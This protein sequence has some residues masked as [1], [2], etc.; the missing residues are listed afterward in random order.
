LS[1]TTR[2]G[3][4]LASSSPFTSGARTISLHNLLEVGDAAALVTQGDHEHFFRLVVETELSPRPR[5]TEFVEIVV[6]L[7][8]LC[9]DS[10]TRESVSGL[11]TS[12]DLTRQYTQSSVVFPSGSVRS[13][14]AIRVG[15]EVS[16][17]P[18]WRTPTGW[19]H[20]KQPHKAEIAE[21]YCPATQTCQR[22]RL[23]LPTGYPIMRGHLP[24]AL[25]AT[26]ITDYFSAARASRSWAP[27]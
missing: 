12:R 6:M 13:R 17:R 19:K 10:N 16:E 26:A 22:Q 21:L 24:Y 15:R 7:G 9:N 1:S 14:K 2:T 20:Q 11:E 5:H 3:R 4:F 18:N 23:P 8:V 25:S 27:G